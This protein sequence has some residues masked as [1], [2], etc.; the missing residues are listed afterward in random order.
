MSGERN[1]DNHEV[2]GLIAE[3]D[4]PNRLVEVTQSAYD[5]GFRLME[6]YTPFPVEGLDLALGY[7]RNKVPQTVFA[8]ALLGGLS[9][10]L[11]Q[12]WSAMVY[13][14]HNIAGR[15]LYSWPA[16]IPITFETTILGGAFAA[17]FGIR[18]PG[19]PSSA[20]PTGSRRV[21]CVANID[22]RFSR[23]SLP[24]QVSKMGSRMRA[25]GAQR[26]MPSPRYHSNR[27]SLCT[28]PTSDSAPPAGRIVSCCVGMGI[29]TGLHDRASLRRLALVRLA[30]RTRA[31]CPAG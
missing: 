21:D 19:T 29:H 17:V 27:I 10:F 20:I 9:G 8:G 31:C 6:A 7:Y 4:D 30:V 2:Y 14:P 22:A 28:S 3:F 24:Q 12:C 16:F 5:R 26:V 18:S 13:Y 25:C 11:L 1:P 23:T 15:P